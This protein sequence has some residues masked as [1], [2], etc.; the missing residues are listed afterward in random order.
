MAAS[1]RGDAERE[2]FHQVIDGAR[3]GPV[4]ISGSRG[5]IAAPAESRHNHR[6]LDRLAIGTLALIAAVAAFTFRDYGLGWDDYTHSEFGDLLVALFS[7]GFRDLRAL[8]FVNLYMYGGGFDMVAA[9]AA[10]ISPFDLFE[11]RRLAGAAVGILGLGLTWRIARRAGGPLAGLIALILLAACPLYYGHMFMNAKDAP[12][13]VAMAVLLLA[14]V[15]TIE[16]Y[17]LPSR[18]TVVLLGLGLGLAIGSRIL[19]VI[20]CF[21]A[22]AAYALLVAEDARARGLRPAA[23]RLANFL[24]LLLPAAALGYLIMGLL[25]PWAILAPLNPLRAIGYFANFFE[26]PWKEMYEG[27]LVSV[28]D[29]PASYVPRLFA[30][31]LPEIMLALGLAGMA[32]AFIAAARRELPPAQR[33]TLLL[34]ALAAALPVAIAMITR[35]ALYNGVRHFVFV[36]PPFAV[37]G[38]VAGAWALARLRSL[39]RTPFIA[40]AAMVA[41]ALALPL[42][43]MVRLHP[44]QYTHFNWLAGGVRSADENYMLDYW[45][46]AFKQASEELR[47]VLDAR[48]ETAPGGRRWIVAVCGPQRPAEVALGPQFKTI[49]DARGADFAMMLGEFY[50]RD[51]KAP[52]LAEVT[53]EGVMFARVY[54]IRGLNVTNLLTLP[55]P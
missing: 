11:T 44:Y 35:P 23:M 7:S 38:G 55:P 3:A 5:R 45:G 16:E 41:A 21:Y 39:G 49:G 50:C 15:R 18:A 2:E 24:W 28:P 47:V 52:V 48:S 30:L 17:P 36:V 37:L 34:L 9:L 46:L 29:M 6:M 26:T 40:G 14:L 10:K 27:A 54:D 43:D 8:S 32:G 12:F 33:A 1:D 13:A 20:A 25:W 22:L 4:L 42:S 19:G 31:K 53:R 51:L